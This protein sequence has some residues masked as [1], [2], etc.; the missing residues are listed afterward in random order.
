M[1]QEKAGLTMLWL[2]RVPPEVGIGRPNDCVY[3]L[4]F[5]QGIQLGGQRN[6]LNPSIGNRE[7]DPKVPVSD[8]L[9]I[10]KD[11]KVESGNI[12]IS[13]KQPG[14]VIVESECP[15]PVGGF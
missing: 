8:F 11:A 4:L 1:L 12:R 2:R 7:V 14:I 6:R 15:V 5:A 13:V 9:A 10:V 3:P